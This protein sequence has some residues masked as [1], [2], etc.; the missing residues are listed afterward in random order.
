MRVAT[1]IDPLQPGAVAFAVEAERIGVSSLWV[2]ELWGYDAL[3]GLA[4]LAAHTS[5]IGLG[6]FVV[7]LGSRSPALLATSALSLQVLSGDRFHLGVGVSG[8]QVMEGW[9]GV[10]FHRPVQA[11][12][13]TIEIIRTVSAGERLEH[14]GEIYPLPLPDSAGRALRP[15][16]PP[17]KVPIY[18]AAMGPANLRLTGELA[19]GWLGNAFMPESADTFLGPLREGAQV[20][21]RSLDALDLLAPVAVEITEDDART[22]EAVRRHARGYAFTIGA[23]GSQGRNFY[24]EAFGR[25]GF[26]D[27]VATVSEL[28]RAGRRDEAEAAVPLDLGRLTNLL[29]TEDVIRER[30]GRYRESGITTLL[31][32]LEGPYDARLNTLARLIALT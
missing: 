11:T 31:A 9:H 18:V 2:P 26:A 1:L 4:F 3:T 8:P 15:M 6:T 23:M 28:W 30:I 21:G 20:A 19:D 32:K 5:T 12:R 29:G 22:E 17:R 24:N 14:P 25:L 13:E 27:Q 10:R 7:Q 16:T